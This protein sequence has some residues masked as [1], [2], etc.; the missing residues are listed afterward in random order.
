MSTS[1]GRSVKTGASRRKFLKGLSAAPALPLVQ[2]A[3]ET[4]PAATGSKAVPEVFQPF[5]ESHVPDEPF[6]WLVPKRYSLDMRHREDYVKNFVDDKLETPTREICST[7][8]RDV[9]RDRRFPVHRHDLARRQ[10]GL[11][12]CSG[13]R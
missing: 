2:A 5:A 12:R 4:R 8:T 7:P 13:L 1:N 9:V 10:H 6:E 3:T 11:R